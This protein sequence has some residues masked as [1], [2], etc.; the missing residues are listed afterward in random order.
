[1]K[2]FRKLRPD[3]IEIRAARCT[4][5]GAQFLLYKDSRTDMNILDETVGAENWQ[6]RHNE[7]N[8]NLFCE[9][10]IKTDDG[11]W[12]WKEDAGAESNTEAEKGHASDSFKRA[13]VNWGIGRELYT[14][15]VIWVYDCTERDKYNDKK[16]N[17]QKPF[18]NLSVSQISYNE[19]GAICELII[20]DGN[21]EIVFDMA[22]S[23]KRPP[24]TKPAP[25]AEPE[26]LWEDKQMIPDRT[27]CADCGMP[28]KSDKVVKFSLDKYKRP[29]CM[30]CQK[31]Q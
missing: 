27:K 30:D 12:I 21:G 22:K 17:L 8:G 2:Q 5:K 16:Y 28:I 10:G 9:V 23:T 11:E 26:P 15:P 24:A 31:K 25:K 4:D 19:Q 1:M 6:R 14:S 18:L 20:V 29:L 3:E 7:H 13:C